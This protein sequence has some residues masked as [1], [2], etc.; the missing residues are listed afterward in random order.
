MS[1][2]EPPV[3]AE[4][5]RQPVIYFVDD[6]ATMREVV[7]AAFR[8]E[9]IQVVAFA[10][11][12]SAL[13]LLESEQ[14]AAVITDVIMPDMDGFQVCE[15]VKRHERLGATPVILMSGI[16]DRA[17][18]DRAKAVKADELV[19]KPFQ[20]QELV[21]RVKR[22]LNLEVPAPAAPAASPARALSSLFAP[23]P[24]EVR[25]PPSFAAAPV[26]SAPPRPPASAEL[27]KLRSENARLE[28]LVRKLQAEL[29]ASREYCAALEAHSKQ[30][31]DVE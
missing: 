7:K 11:A 6:S 21:G 8:R 19:R 3:L 16:V 29:N 12:S 5:S 10:N 15:A 17:V 18:A 27:Q 14:P 23:A 30:F 4:A 22:I 24:S 2:L 20:P 28:L 9:N 26:A 13:E 1:E 25:V 31:Q